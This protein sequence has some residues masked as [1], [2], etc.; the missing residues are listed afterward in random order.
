MPAVAARVMQLLGDHDVKQ[1]DLANTISADASLTSKVLQIA[2]SPFYGF[3]RKITTVKDAVVLL[4]LAAIKSLAITAATRHIYKSPGLLETLL[5]EHSVGTGIAAR[6]LSM[7]T[8]A[9]DPDEAFVSGLM[10]DVGKSVLNNFD[11]LRYL[12]FY[13]TAYNENLVGPEYMALERE[14]FGFSHV[15]VGEKVAEKWNL[16]ESMTGCIIYHPLTDPE[17]FTKAAD[18]RLLAVVAQANLICHFLGIGVREPIDD[19]P[20]MENPAVAY[21]KAS[22]DTI[23]KVIDEFEN[24]FQEQKELFSIL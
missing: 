14:E 18:P 22:S 1:K 17:C 8:R 19:V 15:S 6:L 21:L 7:R 23:Q 5:W 12:R 16:S 13:Q 11:R 9:C 3:T 20:L 4:G 10:H 24:V 2:N